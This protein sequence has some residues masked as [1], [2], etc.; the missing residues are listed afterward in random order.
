M[1]ALGLDTGRGAEINRCHRETSHP[2]AFH[3]VK[4]I[5]AKSAFDYE[6]S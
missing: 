1:I 2:N 5:A 3:S 6:Q 4:P